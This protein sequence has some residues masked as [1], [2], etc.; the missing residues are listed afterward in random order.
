MKPCLPL[1]LETSP[2]ANAPAVPWTLIVPPVL[3][4]VV[5][6]EPPH[7]ERAAIGLRHT[8][9]CTVSA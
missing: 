7:G 8:R 6:T 4:W 2:V 3:A 1:Q 9:T 5:L